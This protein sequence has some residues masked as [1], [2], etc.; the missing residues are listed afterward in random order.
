MCIDLLCTFQYVYFLSSKNRFLK[1]LST[2]LVHSK[3]SIIHKVVFF[4][5]KGKILWNWC[6]IPW[7]N[8]NTCEYEAVTYEAEVFDS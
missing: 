3:H 2:G 1:V 8:Q 6:D 4:L 5:K 7:E